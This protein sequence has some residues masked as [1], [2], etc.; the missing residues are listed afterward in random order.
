[1]ESSRREFL[2][3]AAAGIAS[4]AAASALSAGAATGSEF[5]AIAFDAFPILDPRSVFALCE[6]LFPGKGSELGSAWRT[7]QF[8]YQWLRALSG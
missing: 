4:G 3:L 6:N 7:R 8:E 1:M 5:R 2:K